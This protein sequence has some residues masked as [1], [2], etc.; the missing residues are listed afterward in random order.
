VTEFQS[1]RELRDAERQGLIAKPEQVF[2]LPTG[3]IDLPAVGDMLTRKRIREMERQ[4]LLDPLTGLVAVA[5]EPVAEKREYDEVL[6]ETEEP[7][8]SSINAVGVAPIGN[9]EPV[10]SAPLVSA[11]TAPAPISA[12]PVAAAPIAAAPIAAAPVAPTDIFHSMAVDL[13]SRKPRVGVILS[14][15]IVVL[16]ALGTAAYMLGI[17]K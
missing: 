1:R 5:P 7:I 8:T 6:A 3:Q 16:A 12:T 17:F 15:I 4:G 9:A 11:P 10:V 2:D 14:I 13:N